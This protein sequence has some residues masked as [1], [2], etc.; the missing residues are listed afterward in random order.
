MPIY[1]IT[2]RIFCQYPN[3]NPTRKG[4]EK[5]MG[6]L[7]KQNSPKI[8]VPSLRGKR[9]VK[10]KADV[11]AFDEVPSVEGDLVAVNLNIIAD[12]FFLYSEVI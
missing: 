12:A 6:L 2:L 10:V 1:S 8:S 7:R 11:A 5:Q 4:T 3:L 9:K